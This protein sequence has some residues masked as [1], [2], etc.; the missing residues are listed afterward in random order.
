MSWSGDTKPGL[1]T[2]GRVWGHLGWFGDTWPG[3]RSLGL[4]WGHPSH[5]RGH[6]SHVRGH[7]GWFWGHVARL[8]TL[9]VPQLVAVH[10]VVFSTQAEDADGDTLMYVIDASSPDARFFRIDLPNSG[11]VVLARPLD[12]E[13][14]QSLEVVVTA[15]V[16]SPTCPQPWGHVARLVTLCVPQLVAVHSVVFST[17]AEDADGDTLMYVI[18]ASSPD[19]RFFRID[20]PNS[21]RVVLARPLDFESR[22]SL[23]VVV[24]AVVRSPTCPQRGLN[25]SPTCPQRVPNV[26]PAWS[27]CVPSVSPM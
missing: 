27:Q 4:V 2:R 17:Q 19:A 8:V 11:R 24:T 9:C 15:V 21:G 1:G 7:L 6:L 26:S 5:V 23:E 25:V 3:F 13:S 10:S 12:F 22:Q 18:D 20:L 16:R 14:R